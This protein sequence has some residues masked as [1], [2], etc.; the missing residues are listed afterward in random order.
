M[1]VTVAGGGAGN[2]SLSA[3]VQRHFVI[4]ANTEEGLVSAGR[5]FGP[6][7]AHVDDPAFG[8]SAPHLFHGTDIES[9]NNIVENGLSRS[10]ARS[11]GGDGT[12]YTTTDRGTAELFAQANAAGGEPA[13]VGIHLPGGLDAAVERGVISPLGGFPG[14]YGV[15][16]WELFN[17]LATFG[18][19][20]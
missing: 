7:A 9:A 10:A 18:I 15:N 16:D 5:S 2:T 1:L 12:F 8:G 11:L 13:V 19:V 4:A 20:G 14:T 3:S 6:G 17:E